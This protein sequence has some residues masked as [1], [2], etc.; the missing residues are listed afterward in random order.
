MHV[1]REKYIE[2]TKANIFCKFEPTKAIDT[3]YI[4][5]TQQI[6]LRAQLGGR[7]TKIC[8]SSISTSRRQREQTQSGRVYFSRQGQP[9]NAP[10]KSLTKTTPLR[11]PG[12]RGPSKPSSPPA[13]S[14]CY[15]SSS[16]SSP[17]R[18]ARICPQSGP[19]AHPLGSSLDTGCRCRTPTA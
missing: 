6:D 4:Q 8:K 19:P 3:K 14:N 11:P 5:Y 16:R 2:P 12:L 10:P 18:R 7:A 15:S 9:L 1:Y 17:R 13:K